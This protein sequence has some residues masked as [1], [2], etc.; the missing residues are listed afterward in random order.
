LF[1]VFYQLGVLLLRKHRLW[2]K[3]TLKKMGEHP[4]TSKQQAMAVL[5]L[6]WFLHL[7]LMT[8]TGCKIALHQPQWP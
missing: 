4:L 1:M 6:G 3:A 5:M 8:T 2:I 7:N